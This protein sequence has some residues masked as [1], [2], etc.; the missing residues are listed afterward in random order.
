[1]ALLINL[2]NDDLF[3]PFATPSLMAFPWIQIQIHRP[4]E[5]YVFSEDW[6]DEDEKLAVSLV[7]NY[8]YYVYDD[9]DDDDDDDEKPRYGIG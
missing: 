6:C 7:Y 3:V 4:R 1:M 9:D 2:S 8:V 5:T